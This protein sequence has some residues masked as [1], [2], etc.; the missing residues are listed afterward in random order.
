MKCA[1]MQ[2]TYIP[3]LGYFD[4][5]DQVD[6]FIFLDDVKL[7][8]GSWHVRNRIKTGQ[9]EL[10]LTLPIRKTK[11]S[12]E[13]LILEAEINQQEKWKPKHLKSIQQS[14]QK[15]AFFKEVF[16][17]FEALLESGPDTLSE[18]NIAIIKG[19]S[20]RIGIRTQFHQSSRMR[21]REGV[22]EAR[23]ID[24]CLE[25]GCAEYV[26]PPGSSAYINEESPGGKFIGSPV[27]LSYMSYVHPEYRQPSG[28]FL[29]HMGVI[30]L[31]FNA[32]FDK[33]LE[34][35]RS[36]RRP[37]LGYLALSAAPAAGT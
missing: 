11:S 30:D 29:S 26:S 14:Y 22:K 9:G 4:L 21:T 34:I 25:L 23:L 7:E 6:H 16:P 37:A 13:M 8:K 24:L 5:I 33:A 3:W 19:I 1:I 35:I 12:L 27:A 32:G 31:L 36:G 20:D 28:D 18:F 2:P 10:M 15:T 17:F